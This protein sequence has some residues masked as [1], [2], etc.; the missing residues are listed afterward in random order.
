MSY[1]LDK[2]IKRNKF[3]KYILFIIALF[4]LIYFRSGIFYGLSY[5]SSIVFRPVLILGNN[6]GEKLSNTGSYFYSKNSLLLEN[7][8][9]KFK[10]DN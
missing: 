7:E 8:N 3:F 6:V 1:L 10:F 9:F 2:K 4:I 5:I